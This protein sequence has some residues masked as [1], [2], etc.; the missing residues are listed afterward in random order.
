MR[1]GGQRLHCRA[2][3][4]AVVTTRADRGQVLDSVGLFAL[5]GG[6]LLQRLLV[7]G[8]GVWHA[9]GFFVLPDVALLYGM[10]P[11]LV[12]GQLHPRAVPLYNALHSFVGPAV[13]G[14]I[15][16]A[17]GASGVLGEAGSWIA[18]ALAWAAHIAADR[19]MGYGPR[20]AEGFQRGR[21]AV[22]D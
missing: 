11:G 8:G 5:F 14:A 10:A 13:L 20:T 15:A 9:V 6:L 12:K 21:V 4:P 19:S 22:S 18:A 3:T 7:D 16:V 1:C 17:G 2:M